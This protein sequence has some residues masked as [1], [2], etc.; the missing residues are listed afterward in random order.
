MAVRTVGQKWEVYDLAAVASVVP[1]AG[2]LLCVSDGVDGRVIAL[3]GDGRQ[4]ASELLR[5]GGAQE[6]EIAR[7][8]SESK[9]RDADVAQ[10]AMAV[11]SASRERDAA[12]G[13]AIG[14]QAEELGA[15]AGRLP[16]DEQAL[17]RFFAYASSAG[18]SPRVD[19]AMESRPAFDFGARLQSLPLG[20][21]SHLDWPLQLAS[22][23]PADVAYEVVEHEGRRAIRV[24]AIRDW[25]GVDVL[26][27]VPGSQAA[28]D[29]RVG[30]RLNVRVFCEQANQM[31]LN[32]DNGGWRPLAEAAVAGGHVWLNSR[33]F[34]QAD[35]AAIAANS[36]PGARI[37]GNADNAAFVITD[38]EHVPLVDSAMLGQ[39]IRSLVEEDRRLAVAVGEEADARARGDADAL[40]QAERMVLDAQLATNTWLPSAETVADLPP[41]ASLDPGKNYLC[42]VLADPDQSSSIVWQM[43][44]GETE[45]APFAPLSFAPPATEIAVGEAFTVRNRA[46]STDPDLQ[47]NQVIAAGTSVHEVLRRILDPDTLPVVSNPTLNFGSSQSTY[48]EIGSNSPW[49]LINA[50]G[51]IGSTGGLMLAEVLNGNEL[52]GIPLATREG[53][54]TMS[55]S[56]AG[57]F[58]SAIPLRLRGTW[59]AGPVPV[60]AHG[61]PRPELQ[62]Q[63]QTILSVSTRSLTAVRRS[64]T[65]WR[66]DGVIPGDSAQVRGGIPTANTVIVNNGSVLTLNVSIGARALF[67]A[68][69]AN[70][71]AAQR[72]IWVGGGNVDV[73]SEFAETRVMVDGATPGFDAIEYRVYGLVTAAPFAAADEY[74]LII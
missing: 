23:D 7:V 37:R 40:A 55:F 65:G 70:L 26:L 50:T 11:D 67:F 22:S 8:E 10:R 58:T 33:A 54:G 52:S 44:A 28:I 15:L 24:G 68:Y 5:Q 59:A 29:F 46:G 73:A 51:I 18:A 9:A 74:R 4:S 63:Q 53:H 62:F 69:P 45:W 47:L 56:V 64:F 41:A 38:I 60:S 66:S 71:R 39:G 16:G 1:R 30:D 6:A 17:R 12:Q 19:V 14:G 27:N 13:E 25:A 36:P 32:A 2:E 49:F 43:V 72:I 61:T 20:P 57:R 31:L 48:A 34:T 42:K 35:I 21:L 3:V